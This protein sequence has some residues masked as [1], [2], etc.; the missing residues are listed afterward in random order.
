MVERMPPATVRLTDYDVRCG[1]SID[2]AFACFQ[3]LDPSASLWT[4]FA[5]LAHACT[6]GHDDGS[7]NPLS[8]EGAGWPGWAGYATSVNRDAEGTR[9]TRRATF[10]SLGD[11]CRAGALRFQFADR[12]GVQVAYRT[13]DPVRLAE[14]IQSSEAGT[15]GLDDLA[16]TVRA[17]LMSRRRRIVPRVLAL[18]RLVLGEIRRARAFGDSGSASLLNRISTLK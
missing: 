18:S 15:L 4:V 2:A 11:G 1:R 13:Q 17:I 10:L 12:Q 5:V 7:N 14:A 6:G 8:V 16:D 3:G 9:S